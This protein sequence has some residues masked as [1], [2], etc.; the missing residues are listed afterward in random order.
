MR[1]DLAAAVL[2]HTLSLRNLAAQSRPWDLFISA[3]LVSQCRLHYDGHPIQL[4]LAAGVSRL[5][6]GTNDI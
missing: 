3:T 5:Y 6:P 1:Y 2:V 4:D